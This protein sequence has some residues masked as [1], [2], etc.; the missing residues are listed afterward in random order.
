M[1]WWR[2][3]PAAERFIMRCVLHC[4]ALAVLGSSAMVALAR[5]EDSSAP[6]LDALTK[7]ATWTSP[8]FLAAWSTPPAGQTRICRSYHGTPTIFGV[9][10]QAIQGWFENGRLTSITIVF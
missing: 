9:Q 2:N 10:P 1:R 5:A 8:E 6:I 7:S 4:G 3:S